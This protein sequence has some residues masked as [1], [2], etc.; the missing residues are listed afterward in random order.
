VRV[1]AAWAVSNRPFAAYLGHLPPVVAAQ[2]LCLVLPGTVTLER[3]MGFLGT[4]VE[5]ALDPLGG[6]PS[7]V[8]NTVHD[9]LM[10]L[11]FW[12]SPSYLDELLERSV[13]SVNEIGYL[14]PRLAEQD[15]RRA[16]SVLSPQLAELQR[17]LDKE[18]GR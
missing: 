6:S 12:R 11:G 14:L 9:L 17:A 2:D 4:V 7:G 10:E 15:R 8:L 1:V 13:E 5:T 3:V 16:V 18:D